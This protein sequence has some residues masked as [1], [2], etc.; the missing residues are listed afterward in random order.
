MGYLAE[1]SGKPVC[2]ESLLLD[3]GKE[4]TVSG[5]GEIKENSEPMA[6][7]QLLSRVRMEHGPT[8]PTPQTSDTNDVPVL[9]DQT[10]PDVT[11]HMDDTPVQETAISSI[12]VASEITVASAEPTDDDSSAKQSDRASTKGISG[13]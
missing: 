2:N 11:E 8:T 12:E 9:Q 10:T 6:D 7:Q 4:S 1:V 3:D 5:E 13:L